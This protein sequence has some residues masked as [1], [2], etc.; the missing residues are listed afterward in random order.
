ME[1]PALHH[2]GSELFA[3]HSKCTDTVNYR[4][5]AALSKDLS[6]PWAPSIDDAVPV[7]HARQ[8]QAR[9]GGLQCDGKAPGAYQIW[10]DS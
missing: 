5:H 3:E 1:I 10:Q 7:T 9:T 2:K 4:A 8:P 6:G